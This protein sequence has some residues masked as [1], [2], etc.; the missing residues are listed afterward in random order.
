MRNFTLKKKSLSLV[1]ISSLLTLTVVSVPTVARAADP[2]CQT[3][4]GVTTCVGT[5]SDNAKYMMMVP[6][7]YNGT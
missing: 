4:A 6:A 7:N 2:A 1:A 5:T 3:A